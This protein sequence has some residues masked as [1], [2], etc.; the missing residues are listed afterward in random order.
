[1]PLVIP[2]TTLTDTFQV[3]PLAANIIGGNIQITGNPAEVEVIGGYVGQ[4]RSIE[5]QVLTIGSYNLGRSPNGSP[6]GGFRARNASTGLGAVLAGY[7][8][9]E[10]DPVLSFIGLASS[11]AVGAVLIPK[12]VVAS[13]PPASPTDDQVVVLTDSLSAPTYAWLM[14][15]FASK[16]TRKWVCIGGDPAVVAVTTAEG[17]ASAAYT[18]LATAGPSF[19]IPVL[20]D[21]F[22]TVE[23]QLD[24]SA[25]GPIS[26]MSYAVGGVGATDTDGAN[27]SN[28]TT[29]AGAESATSTQLK[30]GIAAST[31]I[32]SKYRAENGGTSTFRQRRLR[33]LPQSLT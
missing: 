8:W 31:S 26:H 17:T 12:L 14:Q 9:T 7:F 23:S 13:F 16:A 3:F 20:G 21:Y 11:Q 25:A 22:I 24:S 19:T 6:L 30:T 27:Q 15:Y 18:D 32:V 1:M 10:A 5:P 4:T 29:L 2:Q 33:I 28:R